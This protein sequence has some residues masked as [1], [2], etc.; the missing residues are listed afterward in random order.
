MSSTEAPE[1]CPPEPDTTPPS[2]ATATAAEDVPATSP[3]PIAAEFEP[4]APETTTQAEAAPSMSEREPVAAAPFQENTISVEVE[5]E[6]VVA[7]LAA[8]DDTGQTESTPNEPQ[9][10]GSTDSPPS[11]SDDT[12]R[13]PAS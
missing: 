6:V 8:T 7:T 2:V 11:E 9:S 12:D 4:E 13:K 3:Q 1:P 10:I 5:G